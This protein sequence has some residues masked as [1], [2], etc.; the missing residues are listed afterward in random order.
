MGGM[1][2]E[3]SVHRELLRPDPAS[4]HIAPEGTWRSAGFDELQHLGTQPTGA[5]FAVQRLE[6][7]PGCGRE[8][9]G[10]GGFPGLP[11]ERTG[12]FQ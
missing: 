8:I 4:P 12:P 10:F 2:L 3:V 7:V 1:T 6:N 9:T 11:I 5:A